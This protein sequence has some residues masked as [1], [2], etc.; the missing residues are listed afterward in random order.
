M[1]REPISEEQLSKMEK[2]SDLL[3]P[4]APEVVKKLIAEVRAGR[5]RTCKAHHRVLKW[6]DIANRKVE[7]TCMFCPECG[8]K[9]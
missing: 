1:N 6:Y 9:V 8:G 3:P 2:C 5:D 7:H 4:P